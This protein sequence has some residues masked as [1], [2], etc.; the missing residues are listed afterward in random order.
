MKQGSSEIL[1]AGNPQ[2]ATSMHRKEEKN[3]ML[4]DLTDVSVLSSLFSLSLFLLFQETERRGRQ[5][6]PR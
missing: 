3:T 4:N 1:S 6:L 5:S 2:N